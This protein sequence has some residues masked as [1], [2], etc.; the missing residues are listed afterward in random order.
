MVMLVAIDPKRTPRL[1]VSIT[2]KDEVLNKFKNDVFIE[3][4]TYLGG[5]VLLAQKCGFKEIHSIE[6]SGYYYELMSSKLKHA[7]LYLGDSCDILPTILS[8]IDSPCTFWLDGHT[9]PG[10]SNTSSNGSGWIHCP[11][12]KE[13][14]AIKNHS[15]KTHTI[16]IDDLDA[17]GTPILDN[18]TLLDLMKAVKMINR[19]YVFSLEDGKVPGDILACKVV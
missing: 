11:I 9:I 1:N 15:I 13:L 10:D 2:L 16:L 19:N 18:I 7:N 3:T 5:G 14:E 8:K 12:L 6:M 4:G 17:L